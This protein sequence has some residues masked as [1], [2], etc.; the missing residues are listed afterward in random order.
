M[1]YNI[2]INNLFLFDQNSSLYGVVLV[3][4]TAEPFPLRIVMLY[5]D[6][7]Q[8]MCVCFRWHSTEF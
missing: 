8:I 5:A 2:L 6:R 7:P 4:K 3:F 1:E